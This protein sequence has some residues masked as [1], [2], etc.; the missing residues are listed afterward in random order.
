MSPIFLKASE[1]EKFDETA[2]VAIALY[3]YTAE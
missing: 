3:K 1:D 2:D